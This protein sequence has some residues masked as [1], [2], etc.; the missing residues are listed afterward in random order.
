MQSGSQAKVAMILS[1]CENRKRSA[2]LE[3][4]VEFAKEA[5]ETCARARGSRMMVGASYYTSQWQMSI[6]FK[7]SG[8]LHAITQ[9][10]LKL[11]N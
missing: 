4:S 8:V 7:R 3:R 10:P 5:C 1:T 9:I 6:G 2:S 11:T